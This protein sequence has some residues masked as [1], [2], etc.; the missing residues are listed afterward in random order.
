VKQA[1]VR[2]VI[3]SLVV[4]LACMIVLVFAGYWY[5]GLV[6]RQ[7]QERTATAIADSRERAAAALAESNRKW[8]EI[9]LLFDTTYKTTPPTTEAGKKLAAFFAARRIDFGCS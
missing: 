3:Q 6:D 4:S 9:V 8:C 5:I 2:P 1:N 7:A